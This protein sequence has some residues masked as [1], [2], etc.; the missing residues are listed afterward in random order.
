MLEI[1]RQSVPD[2]Y[3]NSY[4]WV[5][6]PRIVPLE[7]VREAGGRMTFEGRELAPLDEDDVVARPRRF[8]ATGSDCIAVCL[9]HSYAN[10][11]HERRVGEQI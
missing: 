8:S 2:G 10:G 7:R 5:K 3:G 4:F 6:P 9:L 1:A 11:A